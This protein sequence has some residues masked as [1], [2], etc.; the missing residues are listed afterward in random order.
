MKVKKVKTLPMIIQTKRH[1]AKPSFD[2]TVLIINDLTEGTVP[3]CFKW[4]MT[5]FRNNLH[6]MGHEIYLHNLITYMDLIIHV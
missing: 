6:F 4:V 1:L 3:L 5:A 2:F